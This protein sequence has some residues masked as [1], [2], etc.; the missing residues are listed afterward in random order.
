MKFDR[1][2]HQ[3][4]LVGKKYVLDGFE[5]FL[6][7]KTFAVKLSNL[8]RPNRNRIEPKRIKLNRKLGKISAE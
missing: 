6:S 3:I 5:S 4:I 1:F 7:I 8:L 2:D